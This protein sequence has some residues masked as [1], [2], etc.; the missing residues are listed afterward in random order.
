V[1]PTHDHREG[2]TNCLLDCHVIAV[3]PKFQRRGIGALLTQWGVDVSDTI[4]IPVYLEATDASV[5]LYQKLGFQ[6]LPEGV[7]LQP[8]VIGTEAVEAPVMVK[9]PK[10]AMGLAFED[11][12][13]SKD[14][15]VK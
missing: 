14:P 3:H 11:W 2:A 8:G 7:I 5:K 1:I 6:L 13:K 9:M 4:G 10:S 12:I 15:G